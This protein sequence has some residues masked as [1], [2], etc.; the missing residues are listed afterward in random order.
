MKAVRIEFF[1][2]EQD[3]RDDDLR[4]IPMIVRFKLDACGIKLSL[5]EWNKMSVEDREEL[6]LLPINTEEE[7]AHYSKYLTHLIREYTGEGPTFLSPEKVLS[8]W[9]KPDVLPNEVQLKLAEQGMTV[10]LSQ[11]K[12]LSVLQRYVLIKLSQPGH[13][14][15]NFPKAMREYGLA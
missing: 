4:C 15:R 2:F 3:F 10:T 14:N 13:E 9:F 8:A 7:K 5:K 12:E 11:W 6:A 1:Q